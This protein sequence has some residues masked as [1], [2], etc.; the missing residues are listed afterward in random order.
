MV[1]ID[2][3]QT[4]TTNMIKKLSDSINLLVENNTSIMKRLDA[5]EKPQ[6]NETNLFEKI[7]VQHLNNMSSSEKE[8]DEEY[9]DDEY[10]LSASI[11]DNTVYDTNNT[12]YDTNNTQDIEFKQLDINLSSLKDLIELGN[13][14]KHMFE[15]RKKRRML[16]NE[17]ISNYGINL[18]IIVDL[19]VPLTKLSN[20]I[21]MKKVKEQIF[22]M[23]IYY[24][25]EFEKQNQNMLHAV[26][27]GPP[28]VGKTKLGKI[29]ARI[30]CALGIIKTSKFKYVRATDLIGEHIGATK[31][32]TQECIDEADGGVLFIDEAYALSSSD[33]KDPYGKE[34]I[35]TINFNLSENKK[36]LIIIIAGYSDQLEK[37][38]FSFNPGL[39]RRFPFRFKITKYSSDELKEIFIDKL[40]RFGWKLNKEVSENRLIEFFKENHKKFPN[41]GGD[42]ENFVKSCQFTHAKRVLGKNPLYRMKLTMSDIIMGMERFESNQKP[43]ED[44]SIRDSMLL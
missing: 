10:D 7:L 9:S 28:G 3:E 43:K 22:E 12:V 20:M 5:L 25:Q 44:T 8:V 29:L 14:Y 13:K 4:N 33:T 11:Y 39:E 41:F 35:D 31:H 19:I 34:C 40:K 6:S 2:A 16:K 17:P 38:F 18:K 42:I 23:I 37:Y 32:M 21:G 15:T 24:L 27:E 30:Y 36:K 26:I 1:K